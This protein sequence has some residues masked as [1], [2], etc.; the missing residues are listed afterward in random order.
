MFVPT[1]IFYYDGVVVLWYYKDK[2]Y[3][4]TLKFL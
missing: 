4:P 2:T 1:R 3:F